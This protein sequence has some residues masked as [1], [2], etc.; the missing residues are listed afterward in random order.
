MQLRS[1]FFDFVFYFLQS[2]LSLEM[3]HDIINCKTDVKCHIFKISSCSMKIVPYFSGQGSFSQLSSFE[4]PEKWI[5]LQAH[6]LGV[7]QVLRNHV[8]GIFL[9]HSPSIVITFS[10]EC[11]Q[12]PFSDP[13]PPFFLRLCNTCKF[14]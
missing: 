14:P 8:L 5:F 10:T 4:C 2:Q 11:N 9:I 7:I 12:L 3:M 6:L 1:F 13:S